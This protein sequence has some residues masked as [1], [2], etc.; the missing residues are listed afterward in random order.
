MIPSSLFFLIQ[1]LLATSTNP[2][3]NISIRY[4]TE[5]SLA[6]ICCVSLAGFMVEQVY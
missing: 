2:W 1:L 4:L 5:L 6:N 3:H